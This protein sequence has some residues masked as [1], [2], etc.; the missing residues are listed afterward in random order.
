MP[1]NFMSVRVKSAKVGHRDLEYWERKL[2]EAQEE[3]T[4]LE[5][6][7]GSLTRLRAAVATEQSVD[8]EIGKLAHRLKMLNTTKIPYYQERIR[9]LAMTMTF[10]D[11]LKAGAL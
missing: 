10:W 5:A 11:R 6:G 2:Q 9:A 4:S 1:I 7:L 8:N 3:L